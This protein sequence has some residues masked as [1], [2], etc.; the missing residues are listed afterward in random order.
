VQELVETWIKQMTPKKGKSTTNIKVGQI[1][2][3]TQILVNSDN[4]VQRQ[5]I[6]YDSA[7][8]KELLN[9]LTIDVQRLESNLREDLKDEIEKTLKQLDRNK[10]VTG[11]LLTIGE[12]IKD[13]GIGVFTNLVS[14]PT[15]ELLKP[16]LGLG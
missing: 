1:K 4:S 6:T 3:P 15:F 14:S 16:L 8:I 11:R 7:D 12:M 5:N 10:D 2:A 13:I 9:K